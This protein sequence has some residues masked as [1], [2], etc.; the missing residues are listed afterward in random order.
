MARLF[1]SGFENNAVTNSTQ[2]VE[3]HSNST[4]QAT[5][6]T[7]VRS[8]TYSLKITGSLTNQSLHH[9][10]VAADNNG[11][12]FARAYINI[13]SY[14]N[15]RN[16][17]FG[18][19]ASTSPDM[20][21][22]SLDTNGQLYLDDEDGFVGSPSSALSLNTWYML[23]VKM[24][25]TGSAGAHIVEGKIDG[26]VFA[27]S[28]TRSLST[29][30]ARVFV[31]GG[32]D[33]EAINSGVWYFDD[34]ALNDG[35]GSFQTSYPGSGKIIHLKPSAAGDSNGFTVG[36]GGTAGQANNFT[37]VKEV[38]PD[39]ATTYNG[40]AILSSEDLFN[41]DDSAI[42][43]NDT[44]NVVA[45]GLRMA[46][47]VGA[48][49]TAAF[50][51]EL[52]KAASGTKSQSATIIPNS[53]SWLTN[54]AAIPRNYP[55]V[56]YQDPDSANWTQTTLDSMQIGYI[57]TATNVQTIAI[58]TLWASVDFTPKV[59]GNAYWRGGR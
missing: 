16:A 49:A 33:S 23:E 38:P 36:V 35:T 41:C 19:G 21:I 27:T 52:E 59:P 1:Q 55:L 50:K 44:V 34:V 29:G 25:R 56:T 26:I 15:I 58:S 22:I 32:L 4:G 5:S 51:V 31:G 48:D 40:S 42:G 9:Q 45:V 10:F 18:L 47:L 54:A 13:E 2:D 8:G 28:S 14:P 7:T 24:D 30:A 17:V 11:P 46:D 20:A 6:T 12:F 53:T 3:W 43:S 39:D 57:Q 37:R